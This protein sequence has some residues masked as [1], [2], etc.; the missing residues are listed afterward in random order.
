MY[1]LFCH[2]SE[3]LKY[4]L[5]HLGKTMQTQLTAI[6]RLGAHYKN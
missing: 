4:A 1:Q 3:H 6:I 2:S 5:E